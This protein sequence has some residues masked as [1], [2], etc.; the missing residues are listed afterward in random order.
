M[1]R[2][3][4][5]PSAPPETAGEGAPHRGSIAKLTLAA[6]GIVYG[7]IGTSPLYVMKTVFDK[8]A[9][10]ALTEPD[11][12]GVVS[13]ILHKPEDGLLIPFTAETPKV[14]ALEVEYRCAAPISRIGSSCAACIRSTALRSSR[15]FPGHLQD[16][17]AS[18]TSA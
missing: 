15:A 5:L 10:L 6:L 17:N 16:S 18:Q 12:I 13:L 8:E 4:S 9:G 1:N 7:D 3:S 11:L 2:A 14:Y